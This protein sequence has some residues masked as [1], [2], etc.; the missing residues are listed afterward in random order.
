MIRVRPLGDLLEL[1]GGPAI[2][3][4]H[5]VTLYAAEALVCTPGIAPAGAMTWLAGAATLAALG[6]LGAFGLT[7]MRRPAREPAGRHGG[8]AFLR[9]AT[10]W[11]VLL[12]AVAVVWVALPIAVLRVC[13]SAAG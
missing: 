12:S 9:A 5:F 2:W 11:L 13:A 6:I 1:F 4:A 3:F 10:L 8:A 7:V